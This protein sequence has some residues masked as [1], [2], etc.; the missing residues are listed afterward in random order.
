MWAKS[1]RGEFH[2]DNAYGE[3]FQFLVKRAAD[4][5]IMITMNRQDQPVL[6]ERTYPTIAAEAACG[7]EFNAWSVGTTAHET[8]LPSP[9]SVNPMIIRRNF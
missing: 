3:S 4:Y 7:N 5:K 9:A 8:I 2:D 6:E 1:F